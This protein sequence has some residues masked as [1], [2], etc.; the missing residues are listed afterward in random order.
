MQV[1]QDHLP[2]GL[3]PLFKGRAIRRPRKL[4]IPPKLPRFPYL[5]GHVIMPINEMLFR[6][7]HMPNELHVV[8]RLAVPIPNLSPHDVSTGYVLERAVVTQLIVHSHPPKTAGESELDPPA[9][10]T[11]TKTESH[12]RRSPPRLVSTPGSP[13]PVLP[14]PV[15]VP[16][17]APVLPLQSVQPPLPL[18]APLRAFHHPALSS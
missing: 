7:R 2:Y 15:A 4:G 9:P 8:T 14:P 17:P 11:W 13:V 12:P 1:R 10:T 16:P 18:L 3:Q 5:A 6:V